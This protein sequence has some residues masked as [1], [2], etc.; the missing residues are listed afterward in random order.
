MAKNKSKNKGPRPKISPT[1]YI[2]ERARSFPVG[3]CYR[4]PRQDEFGETQVIV[5]RVRPD[6]NFIMGAYLVDTFC[7]GVKD[8]FW[9][10]NMSP[11][12]LNDFLDHIRNN[13][14]LKELSYEEAH[15]LIYG[16]IGFAE[17]A[18][19][20]PSKEFDLGQYILEE[21]TDDV[22]LIEYEFGKNGKHFLVIG[23]EG[24]ERK[25]LG[26]LRKNLGDDFD[27]T[28]VEEEE[29]EEE[30]EEDCEPSPE[31]AEMLAKMMEM[32]QR[33]EESRKL[34]PDEEYSYR[35]PDYPETLTVKNQFIADEFLSPENY[36]ALPDEVI[37]RILALSSDEV[38][39]DI[40]NI[41]M[42]EIG[43]TYR[44]IIDEGN[45]K[46]CGNFE[47]KESAIMHSLLFL[48]QLGNLRG[49]DTIFEILRQ[50]RSF[51]DAHIGVEAGEYLTNALYACGQE[52]IK[53]LEEL[54]YVP[55]LDNFNRHYLVEAMM[56]FALNHPD[57]REEVIEIFRRL[58]VSMVDRLPSHN[59]C[60]GSFAGMF[61]SNLINI[62]AKE[63]IPEIKTLFA[64]G[65]VNPMIAGGEKDVVSDILSGDTHPDRV[66]TDF[67]I[68]SHYAEMRKHSTPS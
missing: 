43:R 24:N 19:I 65:C 54:V 10:V 63:L 8:S 5:T 51:I 17:D 34:Y 67:D 50:S 3:K 27:Y 9:K 13:V 22:P 23:P 7:L 44:S 38:V 49:L 47:V 11:F 58:L 46:D 62:E 36:Y 33:I 4:T 59:A 6:G 16:A 60:D 26:I 35:Y 39:D 1:R 18:G 30:E 2:R 20:E 48:T 28:G 64:T 53:R 40:H 37:D 29:E 68:H 66:P 15:N 25:Y 31:K 41:V 56:H 12:E 61:M 45:D 42:Y 14:G 21:D 57:R 52:D 55:G 32:I